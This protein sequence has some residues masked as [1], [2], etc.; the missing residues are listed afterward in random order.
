MAV[1]TRKSHVH[2]VAFDR[3]S[4]RTIDAQGFLHVD[5]CNI[6]KAVVNPYYGAEIPDYE[7]LGL[8]PNKIY[9]LFR[10]PKELEKAANTFNNLPLMDNHVEV[11]AEDLEDP[12]VHGKVVGTTGSNARFEAPYLVNELVVWTAGGIDGVMSKKQTELSCAYRYKLDMT[13]GEHEG[14]K[15]D[16]RMFDLVGNHVALVDEGRAGPDVVVRDR[17]PQASMKQ[18]VKMVADALAPVKESIGMAYDCVPQL[19]AAITKAKSIIESKLKPGVEGEGA[20]IL[21]DCTSALDSAVH[22]LLDFSEDEDMLGDDNPEG[23]NQYT[24]AA[25]HADRTGKAAGSKGGPSHKDAQAAHQKAAVA[26]NKAGDPSKTSAH[27]RVAA[28]HSTLHSDPSNAEAK[29]AIAGHYGTKGKDD[30]PEGINQYTGGGGKG[31]ESKGLNEG[32][33]SRASE[34]SKN[35]NEASAAV[36]TRVFGQPKSRQQERAANA[37]ATAAKAHREARAE[38]KAAGNKEAEAHHD[39]SYFEHREASNHHQSLANRLSERGDAKLASDKIDYR[40]NH[41]DSRGKSAPWVI[42]SE[43]TGDIIWS[44]A[45]KDDAAKQLRN[46]EGH[47][48]SA[49]DSV[50]EDS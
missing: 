42:V 6:S 21:D 50:V 29:A 32:A 10:D 23:I 17:K 28:A 13:P 8:D 12:K 37:H 7:E 47:K 15:Y 48:A 40:K 5:G 18:I 22:H 11:S 33:T 14:Q 49:K 3:G 4:S 31:K 36:K 16:G 43:K 25:G 1:A 35:A 39:K 26:A 46:I 24:G 45:T 30:N 9:M 20:K 34:A 44:G 27:L 41:K 19:I 2:S 38:A